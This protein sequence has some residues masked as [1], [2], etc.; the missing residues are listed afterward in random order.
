MSVMLVT[1]YSRIPNNPRGH[2]QYQDLFNKLQPISDLINGPIYFNQHD[3]EACWMKRWLKWSGLKP[4]VSVADNPAKNTVDYHC[5][6]HQKTVWLVFAAYENPGID[7]FAWVDMGIHSVP[8]VTNEIIAGAVKKATN[9][10]TIVIPGCWGRDQAKLVPDSQVNWRF[11]GGFFVVPRRYLLDFDLAFRAEAMRHIR[12]TNNVSWEVNTLQRLEQ[13]S[14]IRL[15]I[16]WYQADHNASLF[17]NYPRA[18]N[19]N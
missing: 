18:S 7:V 14:A 17:T 4:T 3:V 16:W 15:P 2:K 1:G 6:Q 10:N 5:V 12:E 11:C 19:V 13:N 8:G 9:E